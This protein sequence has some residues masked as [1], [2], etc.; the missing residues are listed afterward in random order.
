MN[1]ENLYRYTDL[2]ETHSEYTKGDVKDSVSIQSSIDNQG[3][4][5]LSILLCDA[6]FWCASYFNWGEVISKCPSCGNDFES[7]PISQGRTYI[8]SHNRIRGITLYFWKHGDVQ[9]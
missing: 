6:C 4:Q 7:L 3:K 1:E 5:S 9:K 8:F 2:T